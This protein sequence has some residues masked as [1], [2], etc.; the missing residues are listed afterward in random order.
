M[1]HRSE[2]KW[3]ALLT[4]RFNEKYVNSLIPRSRLIESDSENT[5]FLK[6]EGNKITV[7]ST[8]YE[9]NITNRELAIKYNR[10]KHEGKLICSVCGFSFKDYYGKLGEDFMEVHHIKPLCENKG[11]EM[12]IDPQKDLVCVCSNCHRMLHRL[13]VAPTVEHLKEVLKVV[14]TS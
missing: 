5:S 14:K 6:A 4:K 8:Y 13:E 11:K 9:R 3:I 2:C 7:F 12:I 10:E 1:E